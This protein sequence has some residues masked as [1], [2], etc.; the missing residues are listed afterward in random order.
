MEIALAQQ[1]ESTLAEVILRA[2]DVFLRRKIVFLLVAVA[3]FVVLAIGVFL[4]RAQYAAVAHIRIDPTRDPV[5]AQRGEVKT[6]LSDE[7]IQTEVAAFYSLELAKSVVD[8]LQLTKDPEFINTDKP[9]SAADQRVAIANTLL[10]KL[11]VTR[12]QQTYVLN[13]S[14][15]SP[16]PVKAAQITNAFADLHI[17]GAVGSRTSVASAQAEWYQQQLEKLSRQITDADDAAARFKAAHG[18]TVSTGTGGTA[19]GT[20]TDQQVPA[21]AG[22][23][24]D[25]ESTAAAARAQFQAAKSQAARY[26]AGSVQAVLDSPV[27]AQLKARR[28]E[29]LQAQTAAN[30]NYG[31]MHPMAKQTSEGVADIDAQITAE[32]NK[33]ISALG[34]AAVSA[35]ARADSL[36]SALGQVETVRTDQAEAGV[37]ANA[38]DRETEAKRELY[39]QLSEQ[40]QSS[41]QSAENSMSSATIVDRAIPPQEPASPNRP[42]FL[43]LAAIVGIMAGAAT[44]ALQEMLAGSVRNTDDIEKKLGQRLLSAI[45]S[46]KDDKPAALITERPTSIYAEAFRIARTGLFGA[47][48]WPTDSA[49]IA[50][51]SSLPG[52]GKTT[53]SLAFSRSLADSQR[54]TLIIDCDVRRAALPGASGVV[55]D[56]G[57]VEYLGG[58][59]EI[60]DIV[61]HAEDG[62]LD[63]ILVKAPYFSTTNLFDNDRM[64]K[65][66][67]WARQ[68]YDQIVLDLP[69]IVGLADGRNLAAMADV[70]VFV[71]KW[72]A[73]PVA[74][75]RSALDALQDIGKAPAGVIVNAVSETSDMLASGYYYLNRY[76]SYYQN[77]NA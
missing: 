45:P 48:G 38:L 5:A 24:A 13:V 16:D 53:S 25:A 14:Y 41:M 29:L 12:E 62:G 7:A 18:L 26:G 3:I 51:T 31:P 59:A 9:M 35:Q 17:K 36:R 61:V 2:R 77:A 57:L 71:V 43:V 56:K 52:E 8:E 47:R 33:I 37:T 63:M 66:L 27:I 58:E 68:N 55:C 22:S 74:I 32:S 65:L 54:R 6:G 23:L 30:A 39:K 40:A 15:T 1:D 11:S 75:V 10:R 42:L 72:N 46:V 50:F 4:L 73:T 69:P 64:A 20:L 28:A 49:I 19:S 70:V 34:S 44:I 76:S 60:S 67:A 21:L